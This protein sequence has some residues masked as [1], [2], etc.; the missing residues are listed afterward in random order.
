M[1]SQG[2]TS[3]LHE[4]PGGYAN[5]VKAM[6]GLSKKVLDLGVTVVLETEITGFVSEGNGQRVTAVETDKGTIACDN[7]IIGAGPW[8][9]DF[10]NMLGLPSQIEL[11]D[12]EGEVHQDIDMWRFWQL[13]EGVLEIRS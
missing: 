2:I 10:W 8:V 11:K 13:E 7:L 12:L 9:R 3:V 5:N 6:E 1:A 4:K